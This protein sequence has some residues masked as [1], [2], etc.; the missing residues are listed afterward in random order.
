VLGAIGRSFGSGSQAHLSGTGKSFF[1]HDLLARV[2]FAE[3]GWVSYD[4][5]A[6]RRARVS[7]YA[8]IGAITLIAVAALG[9]MVDELHRQQGTD[10][11]HR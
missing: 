3:A 8:G 10:R 7:R 4:D 5:A 1:L 6:D 2:I 11:C 9:A